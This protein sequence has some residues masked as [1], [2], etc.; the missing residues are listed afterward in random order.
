MVEVARQTEEAG[1]HY[2]WL[3]DS[4]LLWRDVWATTGAMAVAT[5]RIILGINVTNPVT[6]DASVT[7]GAAFTLV[8]SAPGRFVLG[9]GVGD[10]SVR[11]QGRR[12]ARMAELAAYVSD[13]RALVSGESLEGPEK[14]Y[15]LIERAAQPV[16]VYIS[17]TGPKMLEL[18]GELGDGVI[19][20]GGV[21]TPSLE[22]AHHHIGVGAERAG[23]DLRDLD[24]AVGCFAH[25]GD[26]IERGK[27]LMRP[28]AAVFALRHPDLLVVMVET[29]GREKDLDFYPDL[30]H[31][32]DW[33]A[34][35]EATD[36]VPDHVLE[37]FCDR[38]CLIG[39]GPSIKKRVDELDRMGVTNL[40]VRGV[41]S[42]ELPL[43]LLDGFAQ[44]V[45]I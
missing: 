33:D 37:E 12:P 9:I 10:S 31:A 15:R 26:D 23:K 18:A 3:P 45:L 2:L 39:D 29:P 11:I 19:F 22:Y 8:E 1:F 4:Q 40:Y 20:I 43:D 25:I 30:G 17:A 32:Q 36:W 7:A 27:R 34:A 21:D 35:V 38:Y 44:H 41:H 14:P 28:Y 6:R 42:Y 13:V 16:P 24:V 5:D